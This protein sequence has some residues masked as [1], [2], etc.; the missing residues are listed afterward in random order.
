ME[1][2]ETTESQ[3][4]IAHM[5][6]IHLRDSQYASPQRSLDFIAAFGQAI[7]KSKDADVMV[8]VG[9][10]FDTSRPSPKVIGQLI[11]IDH[12]LQKLG[13]PML[14]VTG[15]HDRSNPSWLDTLFPRT[16]GSGVIPLDNRT[17]TINGFKFAG[18]Q[19]YT[20]AQF[21]ASALPIEEL[22][23]D[24]DVVLYHGFVTGVVPMLVH[25][26]GNPLTVDELPVYPSIKAVLLAD[27][28]IQGHVQHT[29]AGCN[30][31]VA[32]SG[33]LEMCSASE[34]IEKSVPMVRLTKE[35]AEVI[36]T[37]PI[38]TRLFISATVRDTEQL[39]ALVL[40]LRD[41][42]AQNPVVIVEFDRT[43]PDVISR[44]YASL[45]TEKALIRCKPLP[46]SGADYVRSATAETSSENRTIHDFMQEHF[47]DDVELGAIAAALID[48]GDADASNILADFIDI[49]TNQQ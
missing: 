5:G 9:D 35:K 13:K 27:I 6:D 41:V 39:D 17:I 26:D 33:S 1:P 49:N 24:A 11:R 19:P 14:C 2:K 36:R 7:H 46:H 34:S 15:N 32:Y 44:V 22:C 20:A 38:N 45:D 10:I 23:H 28:H 12:M 16:N 30:K 18:I 43:L 3:L 8:C 48:R 29:L 37:E 47:K 25:G 31:L 40:H 4:L 42:T 21:R